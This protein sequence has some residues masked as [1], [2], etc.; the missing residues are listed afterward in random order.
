MD[1]Q[2]APRIGIDAYNEWIRK[3]GIPVGTGLAIDMFELETADWPRFGIKAAV[4]HLDGRGDYCNMFKFE[5]P[6][7]K[8]TTPQR[9]LFEEVI[10][11][12][13]GRGSTQLEFADGRKRSFEW[14][15]RPDLGRRRA[16]MC[17]G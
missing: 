1:V 4:A 10:F 2:I 6:P 3:E 8:S 16:A 13:D 17:C 14:G 7:G 5:I 15:P 9:H 12:L 11:V